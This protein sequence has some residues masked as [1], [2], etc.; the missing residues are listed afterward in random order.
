MCAFYR[1]WP[2][3][4]CDVPY[5]T[6][7]TTTHGLRLDTGAAT[8]LDTP[9]DPPF[10]PT[11]SG[12]CLS[13]L[14]RPRGLTSPSDAA[15]SHKDTLLGSRGRSGSRHPFP[16]TT[17]PAMLPTPTDARRQTLKQETKHALW[18]ITA[19]PGAPRQ[20]DDTVTQHSRAWTEA[21]TMV[22][23]SMAEPSDLRGIERMP[24]AANDP[25][26]P[27]AAYTRSIPT[28]SVCHTTAMQ[29]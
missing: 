9:R 6:T 22:R 25:Q 2:P 24:H 26:T 20:M 29:R 3:L 1:S 11:P 12:A 4:A 18:V 10:T 17:P 21:R 28:G 7:C 16:P 23:P 27:L 13:P 14:P 8:V 5:F 15:S 19:A